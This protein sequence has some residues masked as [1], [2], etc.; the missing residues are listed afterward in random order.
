MYTN[1][2]TNFFKIF[3]ISIE[4][5]SSKVKHKGY[6]KNGA[7]SVNC[8]KYKVNSGEWLLKLKII[9]WETYEMHK[10]KTRELTDNLVYP[11]CWGRFWQTKVSF[12]LL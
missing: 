7:R 3:L 10:E 8:G 2:P 12:M 4:I 9:W 11:G 1:L 6:S 5:T